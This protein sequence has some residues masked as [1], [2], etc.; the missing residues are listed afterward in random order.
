[1]GLKYQHHKYGPLLIT[2]CLLLFHN[3]SHSRINGLDNYSF[4]TDELRPKIAL[5]LSGGGARGIAQIG[6]LKEL[7]KEGIQIDY[8][9]GTS[10]GSIVGGLYA[11]GYS[12]SEL[13]SIISSADWTDIL[14]LTSEEIRDKQ[15]LDQKIVSD[16][17]ILTLRFQNFKFIVPEGTSFGTKFNLYLQE[18]ISESLYHGINDFDNLRYRFR[19]IATDLIKG[20]TVSIGDG[21]L[22]TALRASSTIPLRFAPI[23]YKDK[24]L[25]DGG[26]LANIPVFQAKE[27]NPDIII[28]INTT[29]PLNE[30]ADL[31][32]PWTIA[33]QVISVPMKKFEDSALK[34]A[35]I[36]IQPDIGD[37]SNADFSG[38]S[39]LIARGEAAASNLIKD[40]KNIYAHKRDSIVKEYFPWYFKSRAYWELN[41]AGFDQSDS[42]SLVTY[43][44]DLAKT[45][46]N[47]ISESRIIKH[48]Y[49]SIIVD[50]HGKVNITAVAGQ[51]IKGF[52]VYF[53]VDSV[54]VELME[55]LKVQW[56][57]RNS[58]TPTMKRAINEFC[59]KYLR[60]IG[61]S[62]AEIENAWLD[63]NGICQLRISDGRVHEIIIGGLNEKDLFLV[64]RELE[65]TQ[66]NPLRTNDLIRSWQNIISTDLFYDVE[67]FPESHRD[68]L[69]V[70][71]TISLK[72]R[73]NQTL[74]IGA[75]VDNE[76][77]LQ[78]G[79]DFVQENILHLGTRLFLSGAIGTRNG[80][81]SAG[82]EVPRIAESMF[83]LKSA[84]YYDSKDIHSFES[85]SLSKPNRFSSV[86]SGEYREERFGALLNAGTQIGKVGLL[87]AEYRYERQRSYD[88]DT[89]SKPQFNTI[90]TIRFRTIFDSR[91]RGYFAEDGSLIEISLESTIPLGIDL[92]S[93]SKAIY[94]HK[95]Y[96]S[97]GAHTFIPSINFGYA[98]R[99]M[100][101]PEFFSLGGEDS[102][103]GYRE[104]E[105]RGRQMLRIALEYRYKLPYKIFFDTYLSARYDLGSVWDMP[106][107]I[108]FASM[109]HGIG[110]MISFDT[111]VGPA[112]FG[113]GE[114][115]YFK[116]SPSATV[117]GVPQLYFSIGMRL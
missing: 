57:E 80:R 47:G 27:F 89:S 8:I 113:F 51:S 30:K 1:M 49:D 23:K 37:H 15:L 48:E 2:L 66:G 38:L 6:V 14:S 111:P 84:A 103:Y 41:I 71:I 72:E 29:T 107:D 60:K 114:S 10:I 110:A 59:V 75:R 11:S 63:S 88:L 36:V 33:D 44:R 34:Y 112:N 19:A 32:K 82:L 108:K 101:S 99:T 16:R 86:I 22:I 77:Y 73:G 102:F 69:G 98:D 100:P 39:E 115:F 91:D 56:P 42:L 83:K 96:L 58:C 81:I 17:S 74:R 68:S 31:D 70:D 93:F 65:F 5:V 4:K 105:M 28:A 78:G 85:D 54:A 95:T 26:I 52:L 45:D 87:D 117:W 116:G 40:I 90:S 55:L 64:N 92:V 67:I 79:L 94:N 18:L 62:F 76:R 13:D 7:E 24:I 53:P 3:E 46:Y 20:E 50:K 25:V 109:K 21:N 106:E 104:D 61:Y 43:I 97:T 12:A 35:D 9:I